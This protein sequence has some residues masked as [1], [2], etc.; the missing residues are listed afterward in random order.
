MYCSE[1]LKYVRDV[2]KYE[3]EVIYGYKYE[4][5]EDIFGG[6]IDKYYKIK[7]GLDKNSTINKSTSKMILN[8]A[9][10]RYGLKLDENVVALVTA[11]KSKELQLKC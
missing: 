1:L 9:F 6:F 10:G 2:Y 3:V 4:R 7:S 8:S 11:E 5:G